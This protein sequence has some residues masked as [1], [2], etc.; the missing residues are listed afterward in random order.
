M[1]TKFLDA[2]YIAS[3]GGYHRTG[4]EK[5]NHVEGTVSKPAN[6]HSKPADS[7]LVWMTRMETKRQSNTQ[8][9]CKRFDDK[10]LADLEIVAHHPA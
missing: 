5:L 6:S 10:K 8:Y 9:L 4:E 3:R 7:Q 1:E 2:K